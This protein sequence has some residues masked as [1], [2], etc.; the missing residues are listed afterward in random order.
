M[1]KSTP[2]FR[3]STQH[4]NHLIDQWGGR[5]IGFSDGSCTYRGNK[6]YPGYTGKL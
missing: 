5:L 4:P 1:K 3:Q 6:H 2:E